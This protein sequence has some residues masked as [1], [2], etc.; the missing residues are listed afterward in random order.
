MFPGEEWYQFKFEVIAHFNTI[1]NGISAVETKTKMI[2][3]LKEIFKQSYDTDT[4]GFAGWF[5]LIEI[6]MK[7]KLE[8]TPKPKPEDDFLE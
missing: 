7:P 2:N 5:D 1:K 3:D 8:P 6:P 4:Y